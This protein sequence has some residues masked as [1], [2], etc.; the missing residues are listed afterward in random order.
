M[1]RYQLPTF[2][3]KIYRGVTWRRSAEEKIL[4]L[5][6][7]DGC[8][9]QV[10]PQVLDILSKYG[11]KATFFCVGENVHKYPELFAELKRQGHRTGCHTYNH[12]RGSATPTSVYLENVEKAN[13]LIQSNLFR[14]PYGRLKPSQKRRLN[15]KFEIIMWDVITNDYDRTLT[16]ETI[17]HN[18][19]RHTRKGSIIVFHDSIKAQHN[20]LAVLPQAIEW[21]LAQGYSF[22]LL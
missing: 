13:A 18:T 14:P 7:D 2:I 22:K 21:W 8:V 17:L 6:F 19:Q 15:K 11:I 16:P 5:T 9:P 1:L 20:M 3:Q 4:Y 12:L 10:T